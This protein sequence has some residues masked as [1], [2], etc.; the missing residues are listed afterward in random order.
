MSDQLLAAISEHNM[1]LIRLQNAELS[2]GDQPILRAADLSIEPG[3]RIGLIGRN[4][5]GKSTLLKVLMR[6]QALDG[7]D[8]NYAEH[9][10]VS[11][12]TQSL[13]ERA[14]KTVRD[15]VSEGMIEERVLLDE[16]H[17]LSQ[18]SG[19]T[20]LTRIAELQARIESLDG[21]NMEQR[22]AATLS[23]LKLDG[24]RL[25]SELSGGWRR[26]VAV[27]RALVRKP[28]VLLL[29]EPTNHLDIHTIEWLEQ[30]LL[31]LECA[32]ILISH[33][34]VF[35]DRIAARIVEVDRG[36]LISWPGNFANYLRLKE[37]ADAEEDRHNRLFDKRLA[38]EENW[39][40]QGIKARRTRNEG[41]VRALLAM[42]EQRSQRL[43]RQGTAKLTVEDADN[44]G[45]KVI[46]LRKV[47]HTVA[48]RR[49]F[50]NVSTRIMRGDRVGII[51][52]NGVGKS[53]L[54]SIMLGRLTPTEGS[55]KIGSNIQLAYF[56]QLQEQLDE[57]QSVA[58]FVGDGK[59]QLTIHG[60]QR[61]VIS[62]LQQFLFTPKRS[63]T[64]IKV[65]SGGERN[66]VILAKLFTRPSNVLV[67]DEPSNDLDIEMLEAL[68][69][70]LTEYQGTLLLVSHDRQLLDNVVTNTLV[71]EDNG[72]IVAHAGGYSDWLARNAGLAVAEEYDVAAMVPSV[73]A[74]KPVVSQAEKTKASSTAS[75]LS[76]TQQH[77]LKALPDK[78]DTLERS[79]VEL[80]QLTSQESFYSRDQEEVRESLQRL[81]NMQQ[82][83]D[84]LTERWYELES[85][86]SP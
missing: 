30:R 58:E 2:F 38:A 20:D 60:K 26:R 32:L 11:R 75:L 29:D 44:S 14:E 39:I 50:S 74:N 48:G 35:L 59:E 54:L 25:V 77:E 16:F 61:H 42:R 70:M 22:V 63:R 19:D 7:G 65:L 84:A 68:E 5:A 10:K 67:L 41:R 66:R 33:D 73:K 82:K 31:S 80:Q 24:D 15:V 8:I 72:Q 64:P 12:L 83:L 17:R 81:Q 1:T 49:L 23:E 47:G 62:Y 37:K 52:N 9:V 40:R 46:E 43:S 45:R 85:L 56:D 18:Y 21:W 86:N 3:D 55:V 78:I 4:G 27:G 71:F 6:E 36:K 57:T 53:T 69:Q 28:D 76:F 13:P 51:G 79:I 34:R